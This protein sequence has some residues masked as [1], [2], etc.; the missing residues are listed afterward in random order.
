MLYDLWTFKYSPMVRYNYY[1]KLLITWASPSKR[2][3][4]D[5][6]SALCPLMEFVPTPLKWTNMDI[7]FFILI[8]LDPYIL[9]MTCFLVTGPMHELSERKAVASCCHGDRVTRRITIYL[10]RSQ[11]VSIYIPEV[12]SIIFMHAT[13][14]FVIYKCLTYTFTFMASNEKNFLHK[15]SR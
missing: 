14:Y 5:L 1:M 12:Q 8:C 9:E 6:G 3:I 10:F 11:L 15:L 2:I 4:W 7:W 13:I